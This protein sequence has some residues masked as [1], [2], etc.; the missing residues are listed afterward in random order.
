[1]LFKYKYLNDRFH[2]KE[3][4]IA[5]NSGTEVIH[6]IT[7]KD[8]HVFINHMHDNSKEQPK[9]KYPWIHVNNDKDER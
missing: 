9:E 4:N 7:N 1:M 3:Q 6:E 2:E 5:N 8:Q